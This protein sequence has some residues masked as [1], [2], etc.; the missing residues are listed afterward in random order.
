MDPSAHPSPSSGG[1]RPPQLAE[2]LK[3]QQMDSL[4]GAE[5]EA[6]GVL[7]GHWAVTL[8]L[9]VWP[10][11]DL[12]LPARV[13]TGVAHIQSGLGGRFLQWRT[14]LDWGGTSFESSACL[15]FDK[16]SERYQ[17]WRASELGSGQA[18]FAGAGDP[19]RGG[20]YLERTE[21]DGGQ[22]SRLRTV[23]RLRD[24]DHFEVEELGYDPER[25]EWVAGRLVRYAR[26]PA[27]P[28]P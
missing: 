21:T 5:M 24:G 7:A 1:E 13:A 6:L 26:L 25:G 12:E 27:D 3:R 18:V 14:T 16:G 23:L 22:V 2:L 17:L 28:T 19:Q 15:G 4:P 9:L 11:D 10:A 8:D 20:L